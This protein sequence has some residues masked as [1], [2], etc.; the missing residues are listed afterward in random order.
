[1][2]IFTSSHEKRLWQYALIVLA[3][4]L[5]TLALGRPLQEMLRDQNVQA[6]FFL[7]GMIL[8][9]A[10]IIVHGLKVRP[11]KTEIAIWFRQYSFTKHSLRD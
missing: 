7:L 2:P 4:I 1:M 8:T 10:T 9:G 3:A 5:S 6:V 11:S